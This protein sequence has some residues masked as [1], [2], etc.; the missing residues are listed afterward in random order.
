MVLVVQLEAL[1]RQEEGVAGSRVREVGFGDGDDS[2][3]G[4]S[5]YSGAFAQ[6][7][8]LLPP[9]ARIDEAERPLELA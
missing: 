6:R 7:A 8:Q 3:C 4:R 1:P 5:A 2:H 9:I